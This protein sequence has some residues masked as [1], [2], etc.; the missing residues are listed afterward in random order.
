VVHR[1]TLLKGMLAAAAP[2]AAPSLGYGQGAATLKFI[3]QSDLALLD[4]VQTTGLVTRNHGLMVFDTLY[5][6]DENF[7]VQ[8]QMAQGHTIEDN[9]LTWLITL[10]EGLVFHDGAPVLARDAVASIE[11][12]WQ[13]DGLGQTIRSVTNELAAVGDRVIRF[14]LKRPF[15]QIAYALGKSSSVCFIMPARLAATSIATQ[16]TEMIGSGPFRFLAGER[17]AG[18][19]AVYE[20][21]AGYVPRSERPNFMAGGK[22]VKVNRVEW[23][24]LPDPSTAASALRTGE[25][26]WWE[27]PTPDLISMLKSSRGVT[28]AVK[29]KGGYLGMIRFNHLHPPFNNPAIRRAFFAAVDQADYMRATMGDD[30]TMWQDRVGYF[31]PGSPLANDAGMEA[32][33]SP[34]SI[35]RVKSELSAAGYNGEKVVFIVPTDL[36]ALNGMSEVAADMFRRAGVNLD[37]QALDWGTVLPRLSNRRPPDQGGW[38]VWCNYLPGVVALNPAGNSFFRGIGERGPV[39][40]PT[41]ER[42]E[43]LRDAYLAE[44]D[45]DKQKSLA[46]DL[47]LQGF[48]D[49]P[50]IPTGFYYQPTAFRSNIRNVVEG[51]PVFWGLEKG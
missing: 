50:Y 16:V 2:L 21:F 3:P 45:P 39:G 28:V 14:R 13:N 36:P 27:Q 19:R 40:W 18:Q 33:T 20:K 8:P 29:D 35:E 38:N 1:R 9:G 6:L 4:P 24:T 41:S 37:Y 15:P 11:R 48:Q 31:L 49:V 32:L 22:V 23:H 25:M 47:Q 34:R 43:Q 30:R 7:G 5:G 10:R 17:M 46:R 42:I 44:P 12:W 26:D 51:V